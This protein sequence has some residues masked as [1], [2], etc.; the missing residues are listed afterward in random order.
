MIGRCLALLWRELES[1]F[2]SPLA[3]IVLTVFLLLNGLSF[4]SAMTAASTSEGT[5][6]E[7][8]GFFL[9]EG[10]LFWLSL[11]V[12][13]PLVTMRLLAE[14][15]RSG[16]L[17][18]LLTAP[19]R[20]GEVVVAKFLGALVFQ[21]FLWAPTL[22]YIAIMRNYGA[23]PEAAQV[24][25][26]YL[27]IGCVT[28]LLTSVGL[29]FSCFTTNQIVAAVSALTVNLALFFVPLLVSI[30]RLDVLEDLLRPSSMLAHFGTS[31]SK[32][33]LDSGVMAFYV[34]ATLAVLVVTT[35]ALELRR[36]R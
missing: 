3:Y 20:D 21:A 28:A 23:L 1:L 25:T 34:A 13:P 5:V 16:A 33:V 2:F 14:E 17:E 9:G 7:V 32:G 30:L 6:S 19:V 27:G 15:R 4:Y 24:A 11:L 18:V 22:V 29:L 10:P 31:F 36:W 12:I 8:I 35:R 26:A